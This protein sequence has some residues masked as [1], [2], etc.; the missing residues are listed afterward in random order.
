MQLIL[1][2]RR[3]SN[4]SVGSSGKP[5]RLLNNGVRKIF[6]VPM[7]LFYS[8]VA[9]AQGALKVSITDYRD[10]DGELRIGLFNNPDNFPKKAIAGKVVNISGDS[11]TVVFDGLPP[12]IYAISIIH[13]RNRNGKLDTNAFGIPKEGFAFG[14]NA[15]GLFGPPSFDKASIT[16][17]NEI[18]IQI[19]NLRYF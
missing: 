2:V 11:T 4:F 7:V 9:Y 3:K 13:D 10:R 17:R 14:N 15:L 16:L 12:G 6:I 19:L 18:V 8:T 5:L 1:A